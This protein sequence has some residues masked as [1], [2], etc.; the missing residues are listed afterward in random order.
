MVALVLMGAG[1]SFGSKDVI[2]YPPPLGNGDDGLFAR[3]EE[4]FASIRSIPDNIKATFRKNFEEGMASFNKH[5]DGDVMS[6]QRSLAHYLAEFSP[7]ERNEYRRLIRDLGVARIIYS[8]LN[9]DLLFE[10][11]AASLGLHTNYSRKPWAG[12]VRLLKP[13]GSSNFWPDIPLGTFR[14]VKFKNTKIDIAAPVRPV[15]QRDTLHRCQQEDSLSPAIALYAEGKPVKVCPDY[16]TD[17]QDQWRQVAT[18]ASQ[19]FI[20]GVRVNYTDAHLW[21]VLG[22]TKAKVVYFGLDGDR[23]AFLDWKEHKR[24]KQAYFV[25]G[26]FSDAIDSMKRRLA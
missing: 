26:Y 9:Y 6:F 12:H 15:D 7:G 25:P 20:T 10:L 11:A 19:I 14:Q 17:Q 16:V 2:P 1:A 5:S 22:M 23:E 3:L 8:T 18:N 21:D 24:K 4:K 13:H